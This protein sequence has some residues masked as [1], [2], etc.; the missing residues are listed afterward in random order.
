MKKFLKYL[1]NNFIRTYLL[2]ILSLFTE[3][4]IFRAISG[5]SL[6]TYAS[7]RIFIFLNI[8]SCLLAYLLNFTRPLFRKIATSIIIFAGCVYSC[9]QIGFNNFLG[10]YISLQTSSQFGAVVDYIKDFFLSFKWNY[11]LT[12]IPF[13]LTIIYYIFGEHKTRGARF[14]KSTIFSI[15]V[16]GLSSFL[17]YLS[18]VNPTFQSK[19]Q[20]ISNKSLFLNASNPSVVVDQYGTLGFFFLDVKTIMHPVTVEDT[21]VNVNK[22]NKNEVETDYTRVID[23]TAWNNIIAREKNSTYNQLNN[24]FINRDITD[25][26][27]YTGMFEGKNLIV[28]MMESVGD[29]MI[30]EEYFP[31]FYKMLSE[32]WYWENNYSPRNSCATGNNEF[33]GLTSLYSIHNTCTANIYK[34]NKYSESI[35]GLF[36]NKNYTTF[37]AHDYTEAYYFRST[38][39]KNM[40]SGEY[41]GVEKLGI[42]YRNEYVNW[43]DDEDFFKKYLSILDSKTSNGE[44]FMS[45]LTTVSAHQPYTSSSIQGNKYLDFTKDSGYSMEI[46]RYMSKLKILDNALGILLQGLEERGILDDTVIV[47][48]GDHYP[49]GMSTSTI[50]KVLDYDTSKDL[51]AERTPLVI[52]NSTMEGKVFSEYTTYLNILPTI[53]NLFNLD[54]DPRL[55]LGEDMLSSD[56]QS[57][58]VFADGSWK[59]EVGFYNAKNDSIKYYGDKQ[60]TDSEIKNINDDIHTK[61]SVSSTAIKNNYFNYLMD[62]L[63]KEKEELEQTNICLNT[64]KEEYMTS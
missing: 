29:I 6:F 12:L 3:E 44:N 5:L 40:G 53:A 52:Y 50:N 22:N 60:Y 38:I 16:L 19:F 46:R 56:Y 21:Y 49:Y 51:S 34:K 2:L 8:I 26:N 35:F 39:H 61:I 58:T 59:N 45:W 11:F 1:N 57:I 32:G 9:C 41:Y 37:S 62:A 20:T 63:E 14:K 27:E 36:N 43:A 17:F 18:V 47:M 25:M 33:S 54:Y 28:I 24:Y 31:N 64:N 23:D 48:Y 55:Y 13:V 42:P 15:I 10:V 4:M 30:N 7:L